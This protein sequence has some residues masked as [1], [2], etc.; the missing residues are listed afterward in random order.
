MLIKANKRSVERP[1]IQE[2]KAKIRT[3]HNHQTGSIN[4]FIDV[5]FCALYKWIKTQYVND[6]KRLVQIQDLKQRKK[7]RPS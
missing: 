3:T 5:N 1:G 6:G 4:F 2:G 7:S